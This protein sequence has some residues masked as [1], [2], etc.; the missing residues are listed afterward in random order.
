MDSQEE[1]RQLH[2]A[3]KDTLERLYRQILRFQA[4][5]YCYYPNDSDIRHG[6]DAS[7]SSH[8]EQLLNKVHERNGDFIEV[9]RTWKQI[10]SDLHQPSNLLGPVA[11]E[12]EKEGQELVSLV[13]IFLS[14]FIL[15]D[16]QV[17]N[18]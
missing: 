16:E 6:L 14:Y 12:V 5:S 1:F 2:H 8:W 18:D 9:E 7:K 13:S 4:R 15:F 3:Y 17:G 11:A 10:K